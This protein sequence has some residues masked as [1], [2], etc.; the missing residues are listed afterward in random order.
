VKWDDPPSRADRRRPFP[1]ARAI[2]KIKGSPILNTQEV[3]ENGY[4]T[5]PLFF[6]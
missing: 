1:T 4:Y 5:N 6:L 3:D 2:N